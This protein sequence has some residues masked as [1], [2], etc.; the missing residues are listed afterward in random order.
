MHD[1]EIVE[2]FALMWRD[3]SSVK[4]GSLKDVRNLIRSELNDE[5]TH[6]RVRRTPSEKYQLAIARIEKL[7]VVEAVKCEL[8]RLYHNELASI[9]KTVNPN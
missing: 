1:R 7:E 8:I 2:A 6:P 9:V 5:F 3:R 4:S